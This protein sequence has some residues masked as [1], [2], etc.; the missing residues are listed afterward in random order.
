MALLAF[1]VFSLFGQV[2]SHFALTWPPNRAGGSMAQAGLCVGIDPNMA[3]QNGTCLWFN[4]GCR[5]GCDRCTG[6]ASDQGM[7][8]CIKEL[9][10]P[11][12][13]TLPEKFRS[14]PDDTFVSN[15]TVLRNMT[16]Y[17]PW[18]APGY[19]PVESPCGLA[20]GYYTAK[21]GFPGNA[22]YPPVGVQQ[23]FDGRHL[24]ESFRT[25]WEAGSSQEVAVDV[26]ANHGGGYAYRL[27]PKPGKF[28][29]LTEA[30]FQ[31]HHL[32]FVG[33][34]QWVQWGDDKSTRVQVEAMRVSEGTY[35][36]GSQWTRF[37][38]PGCGGYL[39]GD[40]EGGSD[41]P[42]R[43]Q[44]GADCNRTQFKP[45]VP[46]LFGYGLTQCLYPA[47]EIPTAIG[48]G[49]GAYAHQIRDAH[50]DWSPGRKC[51]KAEI[52]QVKKLFNVNFIDLVQVPED[53]APGDYVLSWRHDSEQTPQVWASCADVTVTAPQKR[54]HV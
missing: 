43:V 20:G 37:P 30:C 12:E 54:F 28:Q 13:P 11:M 52:E 17:N 25:I 39:G 3:P 23:G 16:K 49:C 45:P 46:G 36:V 38:L 35:P 42:G 6:N 33:E 18:R 50:V 14:Y 40:A 7:G 34:K 53:L 10:Q 41:V 48:K 2:S 15:G 24:P 44:A 47:L 26:N 27:C 5:I 21:N 4:D 8:G 29:Q 51:T 32:S 22:G 1:V 19:A 31:K 9:N